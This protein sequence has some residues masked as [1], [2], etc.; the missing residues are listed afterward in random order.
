MEAERNMVETLDYGLMVPSSYDFIALLLKVERST[1]R[2]V[3]IC[4]WLNDQTCLSYELLIYPP[5]CIAAAIIF[6]ARRHVGCWR[7]SEKLKNYSNYSEKDIIPVARIIVEQMQCFS[8]LRAV[9]DKYKHPRFGDVLSA[10]ID[11]NF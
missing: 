6:L 1:K 9:Q 3:D 4:E 2:M 10:R 11:I 5:S 7:W 8:D